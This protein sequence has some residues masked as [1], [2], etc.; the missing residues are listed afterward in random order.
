MD[1]SP[2][3]AAPELQWSAVLSILLL[4]IA[5]PGAIFLGRNNIRSRRRDLVRDLVNLFGFAKD[6][7]ESP[8][9]SPPWSW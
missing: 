1:P 9:S 8:S 6:P 3:T 5:V 4:S 7:R 2:L